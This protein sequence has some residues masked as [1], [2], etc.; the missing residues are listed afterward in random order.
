E[1]VIEAT[2]QARRLDILRADHL[3]HLRCEIVAEGVVDD[4]E[5]LA[6][7]PALHLVSLMDHTPGQRQFADMETVRTYLRGRKGL[8][9]AELEAY[10]EQRVTQAGERSGPARAAISRLCRERGLAVASHDDAVPAHV[11]E[12]AALGLSISEFPTSL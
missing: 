3:L 7:Q 6:G 11:E 9:G 10:I 12:A 1:R 5:S 2:E 4:F 8:R